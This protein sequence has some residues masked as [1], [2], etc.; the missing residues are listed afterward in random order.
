MSAQLEILSGAETDRLAV[1]EAVVDRGV[2]AFIEVGNAL[3]EIRDSRLYRQAHARFEDYLRQRWD[4]SRS[5]GY[6]LID[7]AGV[8]RQLV[9]TT[10]DTDD[11]G[12]GLAAEYGF[13]I[14]GGEM[15]TGGDTGPL[16]DVTTVDT[17]ELSTVVDTPLPPPSNE[18][19]ARKLAV[20]AKADPKRAQKIW[21]QAVRKHGP[22]ATAAEVAAVA[23]GHPAKE[24]WEEDMRALAADL[25]R[26]ANSK[27]PQD[28]RRAL[29]RWRGVYTVLDR[30]A[31]AER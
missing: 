8:T 1:L 25:R 7:A 3:A 20:T 27:D 16:R 26:V 29:A 31:R 28:A 15:S 2:Q 6:Q 19:V 24:G 5:R 9:S 21:T 13:E 11:D 30:I 10:V 4:M 12:E 18:R 22:D 17:A 14:V 23:N